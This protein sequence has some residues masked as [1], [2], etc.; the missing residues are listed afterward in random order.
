MGRINHRTIVSRD[1]VSWQRQ[2]RAGAVLAT[3]MAVVLLLASAAA[4]AASGWSIQPTPNP[5]GVSYSILNGGSCASASA[6]TAVGD[7]GNGTTSDVT[8][9]EG[10]NGTTWSIEPTPNPTGGS[11][12]ILSGVSCTSAS[13]CTAV[14]DSYNGTTTVT[15]AERWNGTKWSIQS[16]PNPTGASFILMTSVSCTS[17]SA[18]TAVGDYSKGT[19]AQVPLAERWNGTKWSIQH[20]PNP[21]GSQGSALAS[22]SCASASACTAV[23]DYNNGTTDVTLAERWNGTAWS[24]QSAPNPTGGSNVILSGVSCASAGACT[25]VGDYAK[26]ATA[27]VT[28]AERWNGT[29]WSIQ[30]TPNPTGASVSLLNGVSCTSASACTAVGGYNNGTA[31]V[32]LAERRG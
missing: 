2:A 19:A 5:A 1:R 15:L 16:T 3:G 17:A 8:L 32:T 23:G 25:A 18:C 24:I 13:A 7:Y 27:G 28:L 31:G 22:V 4:A 14:G 26:G 20:P 29:T 10:W 9:A 30:H 21:A 11:N 6:C 12:V